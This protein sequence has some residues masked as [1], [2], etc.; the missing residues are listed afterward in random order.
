M[1]ADRELGEGPL[2]PGIE[3]FDLDKF[4]SILRLKEATRR[5]KPV[6]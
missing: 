5:K 2:I 1:N 6:A 4:L 3:S